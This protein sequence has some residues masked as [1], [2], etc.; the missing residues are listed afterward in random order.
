MSFQIP[1]FGLVLPELVLLSMTCALLC[2]D[3]FLPEER[4]AASYV[5][6]QCTLLAVVLVILVSPAGEP[7]VGFDGSFI[8]DAMG[9]VL[10]VAVLIATATAFLYGRD[11]LR[12]RH[13]FR[14][15]YFV[16]G[17][18][19]AL[20]MM[21]MISAHSLLTVYLGLEL[22]SLCLYAM[23]AMDR[24]SP[25]APE[26]AMKYF[27]LGALASGML[28]YGMSMLYGASGSLELPA[29]R[30]AVAEGQE[31]PAFE[32]EADSREKWAHDDSGGAR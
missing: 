32:A 20:G 18:F 6:A 7:V 2:V 28:L 30:A 19:A 10:K 8:R 29:V 21:V 24:D 22:L 16:L 9:D 11:Y 12:E 14:G 4:R 5:I 31:E 13:L 25:S 3:A 23:V 15:E 27:V 1:D 26:A 17:L